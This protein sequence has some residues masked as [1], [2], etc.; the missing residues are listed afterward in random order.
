MRGIPAGLLPARELGADLP[1][2]TQRSSDASHAR[3]IH[4]VV[5]RKTSSCATDCPGFSELGSQQ[6][7]RSVWFW[8]RITNEA[9]EAVRGDPGER[10]F[11]TMAGRLPLHYAVINEVL[12]PRPPLDPKVKTLPH[13]AVT[14]TLS[15]CC[16]HAGVIS[17]YL[18]PACLTILS[19]LH[20]CLP[21][22]EL[23]LGIK[24]SRC[25]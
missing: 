9:N 14:G 5:E 22:R 20:T 13:A 17:T 11:K 2:T 16:H 12:Q 24:R 8:L 10:K 15:I 6:C 21:H 23:I 3:C 1:L 7:S 19:P 18:E 25:S 4:N